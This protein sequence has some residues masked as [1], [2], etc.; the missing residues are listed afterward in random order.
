M[1]N[2]IGLQR[3]KE[4][5]VNSMTK[6]KMIILLYEKMESDLEQAKSALGSGD[7]V[8]FSQRVNHSQRIV[9]ELRGALDHEIGGDISRNLEALYDYLFHEHLQ[10]IIDRDAAHLENCIRVL[11]PLLDAWRRIPTGTAQRAAQEH[12][13]GELGTGQNGP[14]SATSQGEETRVET[15]RRENALSAAAESSETISLS[16]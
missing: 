9:A 5:D 11:E 7:I 8:L 2:N 12:A 4:A 15:A 1:Y 3:Y 16:V 14:D 13:R 10:V 6:E